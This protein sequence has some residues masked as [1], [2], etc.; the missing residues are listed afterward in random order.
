MALRKFH[1]CPCIPAYFPLLLSS[2]KGQ[3]CAYQRFI[4]KEAA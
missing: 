3:N 1:R 2:I 4:A